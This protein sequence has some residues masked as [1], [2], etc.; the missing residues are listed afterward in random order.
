MQKLGPALLHSNIRW[1][2]H[3]RFRAQQTHLRLFDGRLHLCSLDVAQYAA[4]VV[5]PL[6]ASIGHTVVDLVLKGVLGTDLLLVGLVLINELLWVSDHL[7]NLLLGEATLIG[8]DRDGLIFTD[9]LLRTS[10]AFNNGGH[11]TTESL[12]TEGEGG[13]IN[14]KNIFDLFGSLQL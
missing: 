8:G 12:D 10:S 6:N 14:E 11:D 7:L 1:P 3:P 2:F 5:T 4:N 9:N 13:N